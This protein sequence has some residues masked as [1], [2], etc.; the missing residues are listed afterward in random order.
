M[1]EMEAMKE[2]N[3]PKS[4]EVKVLEEKIENRVVT[5]I[6]MSNADADIND[7][8]IAVSVESEEVVTAGEVEAGGEVKKNNV[9]DMLEEQESSTCA[10]KPEKQK[11]AWLLKLQQLQLRNLDELSKTE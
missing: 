5:G 10:K 1:K 7:I 4:N 11:P 3:E 9:Q 8:Q 2:V 6:H